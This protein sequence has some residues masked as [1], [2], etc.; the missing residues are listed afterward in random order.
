MFVTKYKSMRYV[1][2]E[3]HFKC[4]HFFYRTIIVMRFFAKNYI[5]LTMLIIPRFKNF[6]KQV[7][8][9]FGTF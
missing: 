4:E 9:N 1:S 5:Y 3:Y 7:F 2:V 8:W 6:S